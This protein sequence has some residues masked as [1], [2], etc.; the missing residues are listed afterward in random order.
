[1]TKKTSDLSIRQ[2]EGFSIGI[3]ET[4]EVIVGDNEISSFCS[5]LLFPS[6]K[7]VYS[8]GSSVCSVSE[9]QLCFIFPGQSHHLKF[10]KCTSVHY[11]IIGKSILHNIPIL[12]SPSINILKQFPS[13]KLTN[14]EFD[15]VRYEIDKIHQE[16]NRP[17]MLKGIIYARTANIFGETCR[18]IQD[19]MIQNEI[20]PKLKS[21]MKTKRNP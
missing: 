6:D 8:S 7:D 3:W 9:Y 11:L 12:S 14:Y 20:E 13:I 17:D 5:I 18:F 19:R 10:E 15:T 4:N 2:I 1:M 16:M 21:Q